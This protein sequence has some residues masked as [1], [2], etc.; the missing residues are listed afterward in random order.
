[1]LAVLSPQ[2][3]ITI[4]APIISN[5]GLKAGDQFE[6]FEDDGIIRM[7]PVVVYSEKYVEELNSEIKTLKAN[8]K[9]GK[10]PVF[11]SVDALIDS[12][13]NF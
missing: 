4:P 13:E 6:I 10:Q 12:L 7:I 2:S 11:N 8:I 3:Q 5:L 9:S 1:M